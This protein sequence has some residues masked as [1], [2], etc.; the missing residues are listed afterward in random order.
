MKWNPKAAKFGKVKVGRSKVRTI[1]IKNGGR[2]PLTGSAQEQGMAQF[3]LDADSIQFTVN[4]K[5]SSAI[6]VRFT[7]TAP[8][9][10]SGSIHITSSDPAHPSVT[11]G[12]SGTGK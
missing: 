9:P 2:Q 5:G 4:P 8:G 7:P 6:A 12:L 11:I 3:A 1:K 10:A